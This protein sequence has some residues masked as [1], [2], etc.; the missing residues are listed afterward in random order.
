MPRKLPVLA[1]TVMAVGALGIAVMP[2][3]ADEPSP[4]GRAGADPAATGDATPAPEIAPGM[5][6]SISKD[7]G[8]TTAEAVKRIANEQRAVTVEQQMR[9]KLGRRY[10]GAWVTGATSKLVVAT[11]DREDTAAIKA[12]GAEPKVVEHSLD[13]LETAKAALDTSA[14]RRAP[15]GTS[16][17]AVDVPSNSVVV[18]ANEPAGA[19]DFLTRSGASASLVRVTQSTEKPR[20]YAEDLRGGDAYYTNG[21]TRCSIG[22]SVTKGSTDGFLTAGH[23][24]KEGA[25]TTGHNRAAQGTVQA[26]S[27]PGHDYGWVAVNSG[28][29]AKPYVKGPGSVNLSVAGAKRVPSGSSVCRSGSTSGWRCGTIEQHDATVAYEQGTVRGLGR[30]SVCAEPGDSG[31]PF[32]SGDQAQG[33]TSGGSGDCSTGGTTYYQPVAAPLSAYGLK[34]STS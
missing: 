14:L 1:A 20:P 12:A 3:T 4:P 6:K 17:W 30:T 8:I 26:R 32:V 29:R 23:C 34:L 31:G 7:L 9:T 24:G 18:R 28:W 16:V 33:T 25:K 5:L 22:F 21:S 11:T 19:K 27:F 13:A 15:R 10:G 2:A